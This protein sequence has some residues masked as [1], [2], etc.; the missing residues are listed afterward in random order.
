[1]KNGVPPEKVDVVSE[2]AQ[3]TGPVGFSS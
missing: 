1:M 3:G 2:N